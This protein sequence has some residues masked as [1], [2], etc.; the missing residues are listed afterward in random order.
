MS[1]SSKKRNAFCTHERTSQYCRETEGRWR[2]EIPCNLVPRV[3]GRV[4]LSSGRL[5]LPAD[6]HAAYYSR[7][8]SYSIIRN[9]YSLVLIRYRV[10]G[11]L[12]TLQVANALYRPL[13]NESVF[14]CLFVMHFQAVMRAST[15]FDMKVHNLSG[16]TLDIW[17]LPQNFGNTQSRYF[18]YCSKTYY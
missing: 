15:K 17:Q 16:E 10:S 2:V 6:L 11:N 4:G 8:I 18:T 1:D 3:L 5:P 13:H 12:C 14:V 9:V 7:P